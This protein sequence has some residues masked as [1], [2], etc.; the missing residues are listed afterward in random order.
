MSVIRA[1]FKCAK[2]CSEHFS[3]QHDIFK[4]IIKTG[5]N[6]NQDF[7]VHKD[8]KD[9]NNVCFIIQQYTDNTSFIFKMKM[10]RGYFV[11]AFP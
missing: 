3:S 4:N 8:V 6:E 11:I 7:I 5:E 2:I 10:S 9:L 1:L